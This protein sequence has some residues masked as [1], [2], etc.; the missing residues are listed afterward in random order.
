MTGLLLSLITY[1]IGI[2]MVAFGIFLIPKDGIGVKL[3]S[4]WFVLSGVS[5][6]IIGYLFVRVVLDGFNIKK[7]IRGSIL[8]SFF[9]TSSSM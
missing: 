9:S 1:L 5:T 2:A 8:S 6:I 3:L 4:S 7:R